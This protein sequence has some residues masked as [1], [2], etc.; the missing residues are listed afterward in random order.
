MRRVRNGDVAAAVAALVLLLV[1]FLDWYEGEE[2]LN[3]WSAFG[4]I[5]LLLGLL[6][7]LALAQAASQ[8]VGRGPAL[9][10]ALG[11]VATTLAFVVL[12]LVAYRILNQP[13]PND[14]VEVRFG[15]WLGLAATAFLFLAQWRSIG[16]ERSRPADPPAPT[17]E[18]RPTP[19]RS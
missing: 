17:P 7:A 4:V 19:A 6:I 11:V 10:V 15:A 13:G 9:P 14:E 1:T 12:L 18:R 16:D 3:A 5:D 8:V 2:T